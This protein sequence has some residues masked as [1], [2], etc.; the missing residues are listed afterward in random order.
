[1][2]VYGPPHDCKGKAKSR[3]TD[4]R[5]CIRPI[6]GEQVLLATMS[7]GHLKKGNFTYAKAWRSRFW[8]FGGV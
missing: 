1:M 3:L 6:G 2:Y 8:G 5:K 4:L 7:W